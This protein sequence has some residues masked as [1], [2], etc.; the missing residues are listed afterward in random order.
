MLGADDDRRPLEMLHA[1]LARL[2]GDGW[3]TFDCEAWIDGAVGAGAAASVRNALLTKPAGL[4]SVPRRRPG[5]DEIGGL[6]TDL[7][8]RLSGLEDRRS[9]SEP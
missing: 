8:G 6:T 5:G 4:Q 9:Y 2:T 7:F 1:N 3:P